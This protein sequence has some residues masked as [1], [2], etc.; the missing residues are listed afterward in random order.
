MKKIIA[1]IL[2]VTL[3]LAGCAQAAPDTDKS[4]R[5]ILVTSFG[6]SYHDT[7]ELTI[8]ATEKAFAEAYP[9]YDIHRAFTSQIIIDILEERDGMEIDNI[10]EALERLKKEKYSEV[11]VQPTLVMNGAEFDDV[12]A[13][14]AE[15]E[16]YFDKIVVGDALLTSH[17]DYQIVIDSLKAQIGDLAEDEAVIFMGHGSHHF[18]DA[19]YSAMDLRLKNE[20][21]DNV[22]MGT[23]EGYPLFE[24]ITPHLEA[25][26][27]NKV[28]LMPF[29]LVAGDHASNDMAGDEDDSWKV[30]LK[31]QGYAVE[32]YMHGLGELKEIQDLFIAH[33]E[34][35]MHGEE[36]AE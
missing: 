13:A 25:K 31:Q 15:Y 3:A 10:E 9:D 18:A 1:L 8:D 5:A 27:I 21:Y 2:L 24:D 14:V 16:E 34:A 30:M 12:V 22:Y 29:M 17:D 23:V 26:G 28:T 20:G 35:A 6:T 19:A 11:I 7:R 4:K 36:H 32:T 33:A